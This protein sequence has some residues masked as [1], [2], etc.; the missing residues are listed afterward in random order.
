MT[1]LRAGFTNLSAVF[2]M[3]MIVFTAF[4]CAHPAHFFA[5]DQVVISNFGIA[6]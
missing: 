1:S 5:N 3:F 4:I 6:L 2:A